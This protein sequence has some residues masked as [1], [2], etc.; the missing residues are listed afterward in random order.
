MCG[1]V[2]IWA[3]NALNLNEQEINSFEMLDSISHR[4][5]DD[6]GN[7]VLRESNLIFNFCRLA[8]QDV[9]PSGN[10]PMKGRVWI[11]VFN[12]EIYNFKELK[13]ECISLGWAFKSNSDAEVILSCLEI[14]GIKAL[15]KFDGMFAI[16]A[17]NT[18]ENE[19]YLI[20]DPSGEKPLYWFKSNLENVYFAS[21]FKALEKSNEIK[22]VVDESSIASYFMFQ[23]IPAPRTIYKDVFKVKP[24]TYIRV[25]KT[26]KIT[27]IKYVKDFKPSKFFESAYNLDK[28][29]AELKQLL[30]SSLERRIISDVPIGAFLSS[31]V[32]SS[33]VVALSKLELG[34]DLSTF[35]IGFKNSDQSEHF[36][37]RE[38]ASKL[39]TDHHELILEPNDFSFLEQT[40]A[41]LDEPL[42]DS[43]CLPTFRL[44]EFASKH[45]KGVLS[46]DGGDEL[47]AGYPR[48]GA[49]MQELKNRPNANPFKTYFPLITI[50]QRHFINDLFGT[51]PQETLEH[52]NSLEQIFNDNSLSHGVLSA[53]RALDHSE[54]LPGAVLAKVDR[55]SMLNSLETRTP[56]LEFNLKQFAENL[57]INYLVDQQQSKIILRRLLNEYLPENV[58]KLPKKGFGFPLTDE[59]TGEI[60]KRI[61][62]IGNANSGISK[63]LGLNFSTRLVN[64]LQSDRYRA[65][66]ICWAAIV[67]DSWL[68]HR[69][70]KINN[71]QIDMFQFFDSL[72]NT[73]IIDELIITIKI[74]NPIQDYEFNDIALRFL[75]YVSKKRLVIPFF[76]KK[77]TSDDTTILIT[78]NLLDFENAWGIY[79]YAIH[80]N[81]FNN[82]QESVFESKKTRLMTKILRKVINKADFVVNSHHDQIKFSDKSIMNNAQT[83]IPVIW[84]SE[85]YLIRNSTFDSLKSQLNN[86]EVSHSNSDIT[87]LLKGAS[88]TREKFIDRESI[89]NLCSRKN[90]SDIL[91]S[92]DSLQK[93]GGDTLIF[94]KLLSVDLSNFEYIYNLGNPLSREIIEFCKLSNSILINHA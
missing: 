20:R 38:I 74:N 4:G 35:T 66:Y 27:E 8:F 42:A 48:Y 84:Q 21:E 51:V 77:L 40:G 68:F 71:Y 26:K 64:L 58:T 9:S 47:F 31:G 19:L 30:L 16:A 67:L 91:S 69:A 59:W 56:F 94:C 70:D 34:L 1:I 75:N 41:M 76:K 17:F 29:Q 28:N 86:S 63:V 10:Q 52:L 55:M 15:E 79:D 89:N 14:W 13:Q 62:K 44:S 33:L 60:Y 24:G 46:G 73:V 49:L 90:L 78:D 81:R 12:G 65:P 25:D 7:I 88:K 92:I 61:Q 32:D 54:Y 3:A 93:N 6:N 85:L 37:A 23:Y 36:V 18:L 82:N 80:I 5:P 53:M 87:D 11:I 22:H 83:L 72:N 45:V 57:P 39:G 43:S 50:S 2:G